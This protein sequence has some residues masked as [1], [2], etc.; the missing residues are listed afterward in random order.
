M[1]KFVNIITRLYDKKV[2]AVGLSIFRICYAAVLFFE[3]LQIYKFRH[4]IFDKIPFIEPYEVNLTPALA[5]W[6]LSILMVLL[7]LFTRWAAVIN[8][9]F[10]LV[11]IATIS[12]YEYH[13]FY[14]YMGINFLLMFVSV[15]QVNSLDVLRKKLK[16][17]TLTNLLG[18][19][20][21]TR[22]VSVLNYYIPVLLGI[23]FVYF[24]SIF[25][26]VDSVFWLHGLGT[27]LPASVPH[28]AFL[29]YTTV[30]NNQYIV[31]FLGY[32]TLVFEFVFLFLFPIRKLWLPL[33]L[34]GT[35]LHLGILAIFPI[36]YFALGVISIYLLLVP[37]GL[38]KKVASFFTFKQEKLT[39][40]FNESSAM[41]NSIRII[42]KHL[43]VFNAILFISTEHYF[44]THFL[45]SVFDGAKREE[46]VA[47]KTKP[48]AKAGDNTLTKATVR[49]YNLVSSRSASLFGFSQQQASQSLIAVRKKRV[50]ALGMYACSMAFLYIPSLIIVGVI[51]YVPGIKAMVNY[52]KRK[53]KPTKVE[54]S[55]VA[56]I[57]AKNP[58]TFLL[59]RIPLK[60]LR[61]Y[62]ITFG[63]LAV[64][65]LQVL[66]TL[67]APIIKREFSHYENTLPGH[68]YNSLSSAVGSFSKIFLGITQH[69]V[70][71]DGHFLNYNHIVAIKYITNG[72][73]EWL[74]IIEKDGRPGSYLKGFNWVKWTFRVNSPEINQANLEKGIRDFT[75]YWLNSTGKNTEQA[76][77]KVVV[78][79]VEDPKEWRANFLTK[80]RSHSWMDAGYVEWSNNKFYASIMDIEKM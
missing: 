32:L 59:W 48:A 62:F 69:P 64:T 10:S 16:Y 29:D 65:F 27:W 39:I 1:K 77:F 67:Q 43:D 14:V 17:S 75:A 56:A 35:G 79:K 66:S 61:V 52:L 45:H 2:D 54:F 13:M 55:Y 40:Y 8:Y 44:K 9:L 4:L 31:V 21:Q 37:A 80:Q 34:I 24:D 76:I 51:S 38:W 28:V 33:F 5:A 15:S 6:M 11:F 71:M 47:E 58:D 25:H 26:K 3:V 68:I 53:A 12:T 63:L 23:A 36:P 50:V 22:N 20:K 41:H 57:P 7:G 70:F 73:E 74:P 60:K 72:K 18:D 49:K 42:V 30:L 46:L 19:Y 78:K